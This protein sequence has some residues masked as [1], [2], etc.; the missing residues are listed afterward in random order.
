MANAS[1][2]RALVLGGALFAG[3]VN[4]V[5]IPD[6][7]ALPAKVEVRAP[8]VTPAAIRFD[9]RHSYAYD[10]RNIISDIASGADNVLHSLGSVLGTDLPSYVISGIP[11]YFQNFPTGDQVRSSL[12]I[13]DGDL[14]AAPTEVLNI[15]PYANWTD[16]GW[17]VRFH[18]NVYKT[19]NISQSKLDDLTNVF[20]IDVDI[21][22]LPA[23][24][25]AQARNLTQSI[26]IVQQ[27]EQNVSFHLEP[28]P[29]QG[30]SGQPGGGGAVTP[31]GGTQNVTFPYETTAQGDF[32]AFV[33]IQNTTGGGLLAGNET[34]NVQ[35]L[36]VYTNGTLTGNAT[37]FLVP[38]KGITF[39]S[40]IDDILRITKIYQPKEGLLNSFAKPFTEWMNMPEIY[41]NWSTSLPNSTHFHYLT[42]TPE[43]ATRLY[44]DFI[45]KTYPGGS[46]DTRP[47][48]FSD[49][50]ATLSI[51][52]FLL[53]KIFATFPERKFVLV[54]DTSN[55]DVM[56][57]YPQLAHDHPNQVQCIFLRNTSSTDPE[58]KFPYDTSGFEGLNNRSYMFFNVP[59]DLMGLDIAN[60]QCLNESIKQNVTFG[61][62]DEVLGIH[63]AGGKL[64]GSATVSFVV[65]LVAA[66]FVI[67]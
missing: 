22:N 43:Q 47:L 24:Q 54:A 64:R 49:V 44:M 62:Q 55:S 37:A 28:A 30:A 36:N 29:S 38:P 58:D 59:N 25:Q 39:I 1:R 18:G 56:K 67:L 50:S 20:L 11:N 26:F 52:K 7:T 14:D 46:F 41:A 63:G 10:K 61:I 9:G 53:D 6:P 12:G 57:A 5:A 42:T 35:R 17:N 66:V 32:D 19:P 33:P 3:V 2:R 4:G 40:D 48:N 27:G 16:Q 23:D 60:G 34:E 51:R 8:V 31:G 21:K 13:K 15:P 45:Y 65:A